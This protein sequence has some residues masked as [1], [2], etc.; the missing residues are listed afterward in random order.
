MPLPSWTPTVFEPRDELV[1]DVVRPVLGRELPVRVAGREDLVGQRLAVDRR[2]LDPD[3]RQVQPRLRH[4]AGRRRTGGRRSAAAGSRCGPDSRSSGRRPS[5]SARSSPISHAAGALQSEGSP[6]ASQTRTRQAT[7][8]RELSAAPAYGTPD[9][10]LLATLPESQRRSPLVE[11]RGAVGG[12]DLVGGLLVGGAR[13]LRARPVAAVRRRAGS[14]SSATTGSGSGRRAQQRLVVAT[15]DPQV[16]DP[17]VRRPAAATTP[18]VR[19]R[20]VISVDAPIARA[21]GTKMSDDAD[22]LRHHALGINPPCATG[23]REPPSPMPVGAVQFC[24]F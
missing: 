21:A 15:V 8:S 13:H 14:P 5:R 18:G 11:S 24:D 1:G 12:L 3:A 7:C 6:S 10:S 20:G 2:Q 16:D 9:C 22:E 4:P 17:D 23:G 19:W